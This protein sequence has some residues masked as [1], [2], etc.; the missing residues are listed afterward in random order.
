MRSDAEGPASFVVERGDGISLVTE[1]ALR[2]ERV[3]DFFGLERRTI[4]LGDDDVAHDRPTVEISNGSGT[5]EVRMQRSRELG[6]IDLFERNSHATTLAPNGRERKRS[7][8]YASR[9]LF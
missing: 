9:P 6:Q 5:R 4:E 2:H 3:D 7:R 8:V 1:K